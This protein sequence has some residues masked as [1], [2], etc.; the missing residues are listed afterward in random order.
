MEDPRRL[1]T[2]DMESHGVLGKQG[3]PG[4]ETLGGGRGPEEAWMI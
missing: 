2:E 1:S 3:K 4:A